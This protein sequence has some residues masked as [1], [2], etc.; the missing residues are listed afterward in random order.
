[1]KKRDLSKVDLAFKAT[2]VSRRAANGQQKFQGWIQHNQSLS[3]DEFAEA[4]AKKMHVDTSESEYCLSA[5]REL[6]EDQLCAGN[7]VDLGWMS[8]GLSMEGTVSGEDGKF[9]PENNRIVVSAKCSKDFNACASGI[10]PRNVM[11]SFSAKIDSTS[12]RDVP[13]STKMFDRIC[14]NGG[15]VLVAGMNIAIDVDNPDEGAWLEKYGKVVSSGIV[16]KSDAQ[17]CDIRFRS[18]PSAGRY[19]LVISCRNGRPPTTVPKKVRHS[20]T[21]VDSY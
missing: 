16:E 11:T 15:V 13:L 10:V 21:V 20:V 2:P 8:L 17:V 3:K 14:R 18:L 5:L 9:S 12:Q 6:I 7:K 4:F 19:D 1:M